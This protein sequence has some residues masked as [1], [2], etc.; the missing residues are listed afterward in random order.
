MESVKRHNIK[1]KNKLSRFRGPSQTLY[2][3]SSHTNAE[4][5]N[6]TN[7]VYIFHP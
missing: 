4:E 1:F 7:I 6:K 3:A 5:S 2:E